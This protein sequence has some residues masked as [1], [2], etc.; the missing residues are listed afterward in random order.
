M[1]VRKWECEIVELIAVATISQ[2]HILT[3]IQ[4]YPKHKD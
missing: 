3:L 4:S 1:I 2:S